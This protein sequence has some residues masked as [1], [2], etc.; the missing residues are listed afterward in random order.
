L[1]G[2]TTGEGDKPFAEQ[3][4]ATA[5][6]KSIVVSALFDEF[7]EGKLRMTSR[8]KSSRRA[9]VRFPRDIQN[10]SPKK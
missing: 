10:V 9:R 5:G 1:V 7:N 4:K 6:A 8:S 3:A 2:V